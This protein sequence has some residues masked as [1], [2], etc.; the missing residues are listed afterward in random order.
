MT[1]VGSGTCS[2]TANQA[3]DGNYGAAAPVTQTF[4]VNQA[5]TTVVIVPSA[6]SSLLGQPVTLTATMAPTLAT[7]TVTF[8]D[9][10]TPLCGGVSLSTGV[11]ICTVVFVTPGAHSITAVYSGNATYAGSTSPALIET[12]NDQRGK[13]V[14]AIG[15]FLSQRAD[16]ICPISPIATARST[17]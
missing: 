6:T 14:E 10:G 7:G 12:A 17:G 16:L 2:I 15:K 3:G 11:A 5:A 13:T 9:G 1:I 4:K 8:N